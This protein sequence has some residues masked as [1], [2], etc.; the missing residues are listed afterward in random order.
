MHRTSFKI[1]VNL[2]KSCCYFYHLNSCAIIMCFH[3]KNLHS[4][5]TWN[6]SNPRNYALGLSLRSNPS[7]IQVFSWDSSNLVLSSGSTSDSSSLAVSTTSAVTSS[8]EVLNLSKTFM[9]AGINFF[10]I[11][12]HVDILTLPLSHEC[13]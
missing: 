1:G 10:Q 12:V 9:R 2:L 13:S 4:I 11:P 6:D 7:S 5:F 3:F 8:T